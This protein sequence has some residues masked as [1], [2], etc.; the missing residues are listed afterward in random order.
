MITRVYDCNLHGVDVSTYKLNPV[1]VLGWSWRLDSLAGR[2]RILPGK[3]H[4]RVTF[5]TKPPDYEVELLTS[6]VTRADGTT[7]LLGLA[8]MPVLREDG[9]AA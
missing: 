3:L 2:A 7:Q 9:V 8:L 1:V 6:T 4:V 5:M